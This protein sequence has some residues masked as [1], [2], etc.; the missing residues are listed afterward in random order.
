MLRT[1]LAPNASAMTLTG[2][3]CYIV[4]RQ[5]A[6]IIDTGPADPRHIDALA[7]QV[8]GADSVTILLT[9]DH[10]D[11]GAGAE[12]LGRRI[13]TTA[14]SLG[15]SRTADRLHDGQTVDTDAGTLVTIATPGHC[16]DHAAFHWPAQD[17]IFCGDL[18]MGGLD[19]AVVAA[20][21]GNL[22]LYLESLERLR[23]LRPRV[24]YPAHGPPFTE[25]DRAIDRYLDHRRHRTDQV[26]T[27]LRDGYRS[28]TAITNRVYGNE[29]DPRLRSFAEAAVEAYLEYLR[30]TGRLATGPDD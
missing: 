16:P 19:T 22:R 21:E 10:P 20:P 24:I 28:T 6:A 8:A 7:D 30:E 2:T 1:I 17:A 26:R 14:L 5:R 29:L 4:G 25:P 27:A 15:A 12:E 11:H 3:I 9:H 13:G 23:T 18:M